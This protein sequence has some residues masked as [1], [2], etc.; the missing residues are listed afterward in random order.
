M[1]RCS[2]P[3]S[4]AGLNG[5]GIGGAGAHGSADG[6][7]SKGKRATETAGVAGDAGS[8]EPCCQETAELIPN[9]LLKMARE[10]R[11]KPADVI[12]RLLRVRA[13]PPERRRGSRPPLTHEIQALPTPID[14]VINVVVLHVSALLF[15]PAAQSSMWA[16]QLWAR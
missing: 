11:K 12:A 7:E 6:A 10:W 2:W 1:A 16:R 5:I 4:L 14:I 13:F 8:H 9:V 3:S 15:V